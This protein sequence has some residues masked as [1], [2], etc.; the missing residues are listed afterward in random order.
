MNRSDR[1]LPIC[2]AVLILL[3]SALLAMCNALGQL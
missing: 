2:T 3:L 1:T